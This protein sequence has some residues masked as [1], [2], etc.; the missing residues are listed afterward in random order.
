M[1]L[2]VIAAYHP[3][4]GK[5]AELLQ[6][7]RE[8]MPILR[9]QGLITDRLPVVMRSRGGT[10]LEV[11]E[12]RS[13]EAIDAAHQNPVVQQMWERFGQVCDY[14]KLSDLAEAAEMF[15]NFEAVEP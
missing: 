13:Q 2:L 6:L 7:L 9:A 10:V 4:P 12:W 14:R 3:K 11:F 1:G 15:P 5:E 8:H